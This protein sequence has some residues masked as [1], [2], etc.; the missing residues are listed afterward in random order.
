M[1]NDIS[2]EGAGYRAAVYG[3]LAAL[4]SRQHSLLYIGTSSGDE[5]T[6]HPSPVHLSI[7]IP[8]RLYTSMETYSITEN[9]FL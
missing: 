3:I 8:L 6:G 7:P 1:R 9:V 4:I 5:S 2:E